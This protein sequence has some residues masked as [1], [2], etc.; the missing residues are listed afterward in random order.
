MYV[1]MYV[2]FG[3]YL[4]MYTCSYVCMQ[5]DV[6]MHASYICTYMYVCMLHTY[7]NTCTHTQTPKYNLAQVRIHTCIDTHIHAYK[8]THTHTHMQDYQNIYIY[9]YIYIYIQYITCMYYTG[10]Q[11]L[12]SYFDRQLRCRVVCIYNAYFI[13]VFTLQSVPIE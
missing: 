13:H 8:L 11:V 2:M 4:S 5:Y 12:P 7:L 9:I 3:T 1:C 6:R 10:A